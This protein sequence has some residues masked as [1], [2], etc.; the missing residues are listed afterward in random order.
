MLNLRMN[1]YSSVK[2]QMHYLQMNYNAK[3]NVYFTKL[4]CILC[5][6]TMRTTLNYRRTTNALHKIKIVLHYTT[7]HSFLTSNIHTCTHAYIYQLKYHYKCCTIK[8]STRSGVKWQIQHEAK[9]SAV[10]A[11]RPHC[12]CCILL[13]NTSRWCFY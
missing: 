12:K 6:T 7:L 2:L 8:Y 1:E 11:M 9:W 10:F 5:K 3:Y 4:Q 13:Y